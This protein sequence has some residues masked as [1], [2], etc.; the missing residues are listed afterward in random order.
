[1]ERLNLTYTAVCRPL[2]RRDCRYMLG[3]CCGR[4]SG[5]GCGRQRYDCRC[6]IRPSRPGRDRRHDSHCVLGSHS[7][8]CRHR[9]GS[10]PAQRHDNCCDS[11]A[12]HARRSDCRYMLGYC[13]GRNS[14]SGCGRSCCVLGSRCDRGSAGVGVLLLFA[15]FLI[16]SM[17]V[18]EFYYAF[19]IRES[20]GVE[21]TRAANTAVDLAMS[22][23]HRRDRLLELDTGAA[24]EKFYDYLYSEMG[25]TKR[26]E[27]PGRNG[28]VLYS[29]EI[30]NL[31]VNRSPPGIRVTAM[32]LYRPVFFGK[33]APMPI[34]LSVRAGSV[35]R[36]I[37]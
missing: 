9:C 21:L 29:L 31:T 25:L 4:D 3:Y 36:R 2:L 34:R 16:A 11:R 32:I 30:E 8:C 23:L 14:G 27:A 28:G 1:M 18:C 5:S 12:S 17:L 37:D 19:S 20:V 7:R 22:D 6:D 15:V 33:M 10:R 24:F 13:C 26:L 35:N